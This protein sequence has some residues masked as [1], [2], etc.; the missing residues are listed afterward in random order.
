M[1]QV[2]KNSIELPALCLI[3]EGSGKNKIIFSRMFH[4]DLKSYF[5]FLSFSFIAFYRQALFEFAADAATKVV[6][7]AVPA[8]SRNSI[9]QPKLTFAVFKSEKQTN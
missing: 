7:Q 2:L 1:V 5:S 3:V 9:C 8:V 4:P 6:F